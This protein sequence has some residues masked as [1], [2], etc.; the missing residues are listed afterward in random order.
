VYLFVFDC[1]TERRLERVTMAM[2]MMTFLVFVVALDL[3]AVVCSSRFFFLFVCV[4]V[5]EVIAKPW[6]KKLALKLRGAKNRTLSKS[7]ELL[8]TLQKQST[9]KRSDENN[10]DDNRGQTTSLPL[11]LLA[12]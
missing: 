9:V 2:A 8:R 5:C 4:V 7:S 6:Q 3:V 1:N 10:T 12:P 11:D